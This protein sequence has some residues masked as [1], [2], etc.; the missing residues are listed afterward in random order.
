MHSLGPCLSAAINFQMRVGQNI[1]S[2]L[3]EREPREV[4]FVLICKNL[5]RLKH[6]IKKLPSPNGSSNA[7]FVFLI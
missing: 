5:N 2:L 7:A 6:N 4:K 1:M 3:N